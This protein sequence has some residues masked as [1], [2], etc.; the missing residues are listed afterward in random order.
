VEFFVKNLLSGIIIVFSLMQTPVFAGDGRFPVIFQ[1]LSGYPD[2]QVYLYILGLNASDQWCR[3]LPDGAMLPVDPADADA[4]GHLTKN[5]VNYANYSFPLSQ[6]ANFRMPSH[7]SGGRLYISLGSPLYFPIGNNAWGGPDLLNPSDPNVDIC[8]DWYE[9]TYSYN[10][11]AFGG[12]TTQVDQFGFPMTVRLRQDSISYDETVGIALSRDRV[13]GDYNKSV[14]PEFRSLAGPH[15]I[16]APRSSARFRPGGSGEHYLRAY[17]D[18]IWEY[19]TTNEFTLNRLNVTFSGRVADNRLRFSR[20]PA[21]PDGPG[22][23]FLDKPSTID[24][25]ACSGSLARDGMSTTELELGAELGAAF[26]RGVARITSIWYSPERYYADTIRNDYAG[27][28]HEISIDNR[29]YCFAYDDVN[30]QS[31]VKILPNT[32]PP[33][34]LT[35]RIQ[36]MQ[37]TGVE[38]SAGSPGGSCKPARQI[39]S[40]HYRFFNENQDY[41][42]SLSLVSLNGKTVLR[43]AR[44]Q[45]AMPDAR[46][47]PGGIYYMCTTDKRGIVSTVRILRLSGYRPIFPAW[48][49]FDF[50]SQHSQ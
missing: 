47:L 39:Q 28:F 16:I 40:L 3:L 10:H 29:A 2:D 6:A 37:S 32:D 5:A 27:F 15:R 31:T 1:N 45:D 42:G 4:P 30:D 18:R 36:P 50:F 46:K 13:Y 25:F 12:N 48:S 34:S 43:N 14:A 21:G 44:F 11:I 24:V 41:N 38:R 8:F 49:R 19:F 7:I 26:N 20:A 22:P 23:F 35:I 17:I 9:F 33:T